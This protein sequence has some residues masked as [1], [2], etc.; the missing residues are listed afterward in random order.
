MSLAFLSHNLQLPRKTTLTM[1]STNPS[2]PSL[3]ATHSKHPLPLTVEDIT[4]TWFSA[5]LQIPVATATTLRVIP[6]TATKVLVHLTY[7][8]TITTAKGAD[9]PPPP[10]LP[11]HVCV[12]GGFDPALL[13]TLGLA[14]VYR[15]EAQFFHHIA[16]GLA[17]DSSVRLPRC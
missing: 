17:A 14:A 10:P 8:P 5:I 13:R 3:D 1:D 12:K 15:R 9:P 4:A 11:T 6:S 2:A 7:P 16:P